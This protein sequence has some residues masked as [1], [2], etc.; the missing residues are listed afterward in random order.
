MKD[1]TL[2]STLKDIEQ[3]YDDYDKKN[4]IRK[5]FTE[6]GGMEAIRKSQQNNDIREKYME[7]TRRRLK[8]KI[9]LKKE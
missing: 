6:M 5:L 3:S 9:C 8:L 2:I 4:I 1:P 7:M